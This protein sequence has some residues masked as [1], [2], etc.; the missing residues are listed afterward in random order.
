MVI[1]D[2]SNP[3]RLCRQPAFIGILLQEIRDKLCGLPGRIVQHAVDPQ[4]AVLNARRADLFMGILYA[5]LDDIS[6][7]K[8]RPNKV[9]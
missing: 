9:C 4:R 8:F 2:D 1:I 6:V 3:D 7:F 5:G